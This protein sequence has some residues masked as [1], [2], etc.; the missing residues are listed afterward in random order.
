MFKHI[1]GVVLITTLI[2]FILFLQPITSVFSK[3]S[4][5]VSIDETIDSDIINKFSSKNI[6]I[7]FGYV[8]CQSV[9][10]PRL[11]ELS[12]IFSAYKEEDLSVAFIDLNPNRDPES[13][14][15]FAQFFNKNFYGLHLEKKDLE[16]LKKEFKVYSAKINSA[17]DISHSS[18][19]YLAQKNR[20]N[21]KLK[22]IYTNVPFN[23]EDILKDLYGTL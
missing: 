15:L 16:K 11:T 18:F 23:K 9:C 14:K 1:L 6:L 13:S 12:E 4:G 17:D 22:Y 3:Q 5:K 8:G 20:N 10:T 21:Y 7:Y 19:L 2:S